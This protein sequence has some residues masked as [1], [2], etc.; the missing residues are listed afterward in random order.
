MRTILFALALFTAI[1]ASAYDFGGNEIFIPVVSRVPGANGTQWRTDLTVTNRS[2]DFPT[3][4]SM[5]FFPQD[6]EAIQHKFTLDPLQTRTMNDFLFTTYGVTQ[7]AGTVWLGAADERVKI[8]ANARIYNTGNA[9][10]EFGQV[11]HGL[12]PES[13]S[14]TA[15]LHG[16]TGINGNRTNIG[17]ANPNNEAAHF[18]LTWYD[19]EGE[20]HGSVSLAI[21]PWEV[22]LINDV[23]AYV[24]HP[25]DEGFTVRVRASNV[26]IYAYASVVRN[27]TGDAYTIIGSGEQ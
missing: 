8:V 3:E 13:L 9:A 4:V 16:L 21:D 6:G 10:G 14:R 1:P 19:K 18:S 24:D 12:P 22:M 11:I 7:R 23:F 20:S 5:F 2:D 25:H 17:I 26:P 15:W 27:D